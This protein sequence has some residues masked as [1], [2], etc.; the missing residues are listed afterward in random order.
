MIF[1]SFLISKSNVNA[2]LSV[3][4]NFTG[5]QQVWTVPVGVTSV[6]IECW[7]AGISS[8]TAYGGYAKG[9]KVVTGGQTLYIY[10]GGSNGYNGGGSGINGSLNGGGATDVRISGTSLANRV[11]VAGGAGGLGGGD[12]FGYGGHGGGTS[13]GDGGA[14][15]TGGVATGGTQISGYQLG[16]GENGQADFFGGGGGSSYI[17]G[18]TNATTTSGVRTGNGLVRITVATAIP[19]VFISSPS[20]AFTGT[21]LVTYTVT[22]DEYA[23]T[24]SLRNQDI[25]LNKSGTADGIVE[26]TN[27]ITN[28]PTVTIS[29]ITGEGTLGISVAASRAWNTTP[30]YAPAAGPSATFTVDSTPPDVPIIDANPTTPTNMDVI[31][32]ITYPIDATIKEYKIGLG[33]WTSYTVALTITTNSTVYARCYDDAGNP[34][35]QSSLSIVNINE[36]GPV[37]T[38]D[39]TSRIKSES[40]ISVEITVTADSGIDSWEYEWSEA[41]TPTGSWTSGATDTQTLTQTANG[42]W[43]LHVRATDNEANEVTE[44]Y[45]IYK[46]GAVQVSEG[47]TEGT[48]KQDRKSFRYYIGKDNNGINKIMLVAGN[49]GGSVAQ[50]FGKDDVIDLDNKFKDEIFYI[51][52]DGKIQQY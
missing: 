32:T 1:G 40:D 18:L 25:I 6:Q 46:K 42:T 28:T 21:G 41:T 36:T 37:I 50:T 20:A 48:E 39:I 29:D 23:T 22:Y 2:A 24:V 52:R 44:R 14:S 34:S 15:S 12:S 43:Y 51:D 16:V 31:V 30:D 35:T 38:P 33:V 4:Y 13:G 9:T 49:H 8:N 19:G 11:I 5:G 27:G 7:G 10:V 45:G 26:V 17:T 3:D 47:Y